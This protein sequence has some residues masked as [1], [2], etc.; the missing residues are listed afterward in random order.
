MEVTRSNLH[1]KAVNH[2]S[3]CLNRSEWNVFPFDVLSGWYQNIDTFRFFC[4]RWNVAPFQIKIA[5]EFYQRNG[6]VVHE[7]VASFRVIDI[8]S[9]MWAQRWIDLN[10]WIISKFIYL[11]PVSCINYGI[12]VCDALFSSVFF[13]LC[14]DVLSCCI[15]SLVNVRR[16]TKDSIIQSSEMRK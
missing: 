12:S 10:L 8:W 14:V 6:F 11:G 13:S 15:S 1:Q 9:R 4:M 7:T 2:F 5:S 3:I 16:S